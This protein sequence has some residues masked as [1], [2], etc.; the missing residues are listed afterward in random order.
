[1]PDRLAWR[2]GTCDSKF[3]Q[4]H[5]RSTDE[6]SGVSG[7]NGVSGA[8]DAESKEQINSRN[9]RKEFRE[10]KLRKTH[11]QPDDKTPQTGHP[12]EGPWQVKQARFGQ[13]H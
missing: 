1:M 8:R 13:D 3:M 2:S 10:V 9:S 11:R 4:A 7:A 12:E 6:S 5:E